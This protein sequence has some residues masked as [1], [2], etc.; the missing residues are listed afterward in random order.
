MPELP[1][2]ECVRR[3]LVAAQLQAPITHVYR[4]AKALRTGAHYRPERV[5]SLVGH[6]LGRV[7]RRGKFLLL[8]FDQAAEA[9]GPPLTLLVHLGMSGRLAVVEDGVQMEPHTH[10]RLAFADAREL[11]FVDARRFGALRVCPRAEVTDRPPVRDL[12]P[13]PLDPSFDGTRLAAR[14][15][16]ARRAIRDVL[17]D[18]AAVAGVGNIYVSEALFEARVHPLT[19]AHRLGPVTYDRL[20]S[21]IRDVL[22]QAVDRGGTTLRDYRDA[23]GA[24]GENQHHLRVYGRANQPCP[25]CGEPLTGFVHGGRSGVFCPRDQPRRRHW[26]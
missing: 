2:V 5:R 10:L 1:E 14:A 4:S 18:Q 6:R 16:R 12:G 20:A 23:A 24:R 15:A 26:P 3:G 22:R 13:E 17:L 21:A 25:A 8:D 7:W 11:R 19:P 9:A